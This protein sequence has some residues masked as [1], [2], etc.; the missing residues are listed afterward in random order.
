MSAI[1]PIWSLTQ[2]EIVRFLRQRSRVTGA[3]AQPIIF[4]V[5]FGVG[6]SGS[7]RMPGAA[8]GGLSYQAYFIPGIAA[9]IVLFTAIFSS[10]SVIQDRNEGFMQGVLAAPVPRSSLVLGKIMGGTLLAF[11]QALLFIGL[12]L[13]L[14]ATGLVTL[15]FSLSL[16]RFVA[17]CLLILLMGL[18]LCGLGFFFAWRLDSVQGFHAIMSVLL[19]PMW[20]MSGAFFPSE[21]SG[22]LK[23]IIAINPMTYGVAGLRRIMFP[24]SSAA[25]PSLAVCF[26]VTALF[27]V[28]MVTIDTLLARR[29]QT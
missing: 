25:L 24:E 9:M 4:W 23:W 29:P 16:G 2:R 28:V 17:S 20:L 13:L 19:F 1:L 21:G 10:I 27:A 3:F 22:W 15:E 11:V 14:K 5:L 26:A 18:G 8:E 6:L 12:A 7:F